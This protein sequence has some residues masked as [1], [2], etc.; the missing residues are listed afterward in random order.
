VGLGFPPLKVAVLTLIMNTVPVSFGAVG[1][2]TWFGMGQVGLSEAELLQIGFK[3]ALIHGVAALVMPIIALL[4]VMDWRA[5]RPNL[6]F[7]YVSILSCIV[8]YVI[9]ARFN[10]EFPALLA[11]MIGFGL[12]ILL[13]R[14]GIGLAA[15]GDRSKG[16]SNISLGQLTKALFPLWATVLVLV[17]TRIEPLG[18]KGFLNDATPTLELPLGTLG[19]FSVSSSLV[20]VLSN[21]FH[22]DSSWTLPLLYIPA[23]IPFFLVSV[24]AFAVYRLE[25]TV[26]TRIASECYVRMIDTMIALFGA[27]VMV[28]LLMVGG[29]NSMVII[30]GEGFARLTGEYWQYVASLLGALGT[31]FSGSATI[32]NLTFAA[33]QDS[34][35]RDLSLNRMVILSLQSVG[36]A[37]GNMVSINN[38]VAVCSILGVVNREGWILKK[39]LVPMLLYAIIAGLVG[40]LL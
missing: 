40:P 22:A 32:S 36:A 13:A 26:I 14:V 4:A 19:H 33:I 18:I 28:S 10:Y 17:V 37:L 16:S 15:G 27:V 8:P 35:A 38:I 31:F 6:G 21:I 39:T 7:V 25:K 5:L 29:E 34:I 11:G 24:I 3:S 2:P 20:L 23:I 12:S 9:L 1:T 30:V